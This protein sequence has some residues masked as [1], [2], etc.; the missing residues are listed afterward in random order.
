MAQLETIVADGYDR[1][2]FLRVLRSEPRLETSMSRALPILPNARHLMGDLFSVLFKLNVELRSER[3][4]SPAVLF[5]RH[6]VKIVLASHGLAELKEQT[7]LDEARTAAALGPL[8]DRVLLAISKE[9]RVDGRALQ[10]IADI[11]EDEDRLT[12]LIAELE[13]LTE[14]PEGAISEEERPNL[15]ATLDGEV[16]S[17]QSKISRARKEQLEHLANLPD[18]M[19]ELIERK[20]A[21]MPKEMDEAS[22]TVRGLGLGAGEL[23]RKDTDAS[24]ELGDRLMRSK[25][26]KLLAQLT[27]A[28]R[29]VAFA[30]RR[31]RIPKAQQEVHAVTTGRDLDRLLPSELV[32]LPK[33]RHALHLDFLRKLAEGEL[34]QYE[35]IAHATR[36]PIV[37]CVDGSGSMHGSKEIWAKAV[38]LTLMEIARRERRACLAIVFSDAGQMAE[39]ELLERGPVS[40]GR[41]RVRSEE[42]LRFAEHF[43]GGGTDFEGPLSR[44][45]DAVTEGK[46]RRGD[47]VFITDGEASVSA[48]LLERLS[49]ERKRHAFQIRGVL[50]NVGMSHRAETLERF[51]DEVLRVTDLGTDAVGDLFA[52][53]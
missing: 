45:T 40:A 48:E 19:D 35:L 52:A 50:V 51:A 46:H 4:V 53:V 23:D 20:V 5:H 41:G 34:L 15:K 39:F 9:R 25:K 10:R 18:E 43:P 1:D 36:G 21:L 38:A 16:E 2:V 31:G 12:Q 42:V 24:L 28:L 6:L 14:L 32:G 33:L 49:I 3:E 8:F 11:A 37:V 29:E 44:A 30:A 7:Q 22:S 26:L 13:A 47:I 27:G 17:L